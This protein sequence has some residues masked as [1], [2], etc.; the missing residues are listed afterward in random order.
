MRRSGLLLGASLAAAI[1]IA[2]VPAT[3][4][5]CGGCFGPSQTVQVVTNHRMVMSIRPSETILWDQIRY[6]GDPGDFSW[7]LPVA[8]DVRIE[9]ATNEFF[10]ILDLA[11]SPRIQAPPSRFNCAVRGAIDSQTPTASAAADAG[12]G[13]T[14]VQQSVVGPYQTVTLRS[15]D[16]NALTTWLRSNAYVIPAAIEPV[17]QF[18]VTRRMDFVALRLRPDVGVNAMQPIR[19]RYASANTVL[20]LRMV[21]AGISDKVGITLE[22]FG[23]SRYEA[24]NFANG[25]VDR[26]SIV[27]NWNTNTSNYSEVFAATL[28]SLANGRAWITEF[29]EDAAS[30]RWRFQYLGGLANAADVQAD[31]ALASGNDAS[32]MWITRLRTDLAANFLDADLVL[33][34]SA[35][36]TPI[37]SFV[38]V[39][40]GNEIGTGPIPPGCEPAPAQAIG[41]VDGGSVSV[42]TPMGTNATA[43]GPRAGGGC[44]VALGRDGRRATWLL[45]A[46][47][48]GVLAGARRRRAQKARGQ[49]SRAT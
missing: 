41:S 34:A 33:Q 31:W 4:W 46:S 14:I 16:P 22:V 9:L 10:D 47:M 45:G 48:A 13:V 43:V 39:R 24:A 27:W 28:R 49:V 21:A 35:W 42:G 2:A 37:S 25:T 19:I 6:T 23:T 26:D 8:G 29:A 11:T 7:V 18:Y 20:P 30:Y 32:G 44:S 36:P 38:Q 15:T 1:G 40:Q 3:S 12:A 5:A 17:I